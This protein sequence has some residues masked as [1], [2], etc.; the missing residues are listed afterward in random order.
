MGVASGVAVGSAV[1]VASGVDDASL[2]GADW[3]AVNTDRLSI[4]AQHSAKILFFKGDSSN[5][6]NYKV[7]IDQFS[8]KCNRNCDFMHPRLEDLS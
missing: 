5:T 2:A 8:A 3:Q 4:K 7:I 1:A 6:M